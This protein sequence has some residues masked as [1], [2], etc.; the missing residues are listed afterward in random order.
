MKTQLALLNLLAIKAAASDD[1][2]PF[3]ARSSDQPP[4][5]TPWEVSKVCLKNSKTL[6]TLKW[7]LQD[8]SSGGKLEDDSSISPKESHCLELGDIPGISE[9]DA[10]STVAWKSVS[11]TRTECQSQHQV[12]YSSKGVT[13]AFTCDGTPMLCS[14]DDVD[15]TCE[16]AGTASGDWDLRTLVNGS[17]F[18][19]RW[20][21][22]FENVV[23]CD[24]VLFPKNDEELRAYLAYA[25][26]N[27]YKVRVAGGTHSATG[28]VSQSSSQGTNTV[29][30]SLGRYHLSDDSWCSEGDFCLDTSKGLARANA[31]RSWLDLYQAIRP[32]GWFVPTQTAGY[33][34]SIAGTVLGTVHGGAYGKTFLHGYVQ[35]MRVMLWD[36]TIQVIEGDEIR[37]WRSSYGLLGVLL[38]VE[39]EVIH[40]ETFEMYTLTSDYQ[41]WNE[42][43]F[44]QFVVGDAEAD[45]DIS[46]F[47]GSKDINQTKE[48]VY[49]EYFLDFLTDSSGDAHFRT[50]GVLWKTPPNPK[51]NKT[52]AE[53]REE[54]D[55]SEEEKG[56]IRER[57]GEKIDII[58]EILGGAPLM[59]TVAVANLLMKSN[60]MGQTNYVNTASDTVNDGFWVGGAPNVNIAA[61]FVPVENSFEA[62]DYVRSQVR[63]RHYGGDDNCFKFNNPVEYRFVE[64][65]DDSLLQIVPPGSYVVSEILGFVD[66]APAG[67]SWQRAY[68]EIECEWT[69]RHGGKPHL[70]KLHSFGDDD[71]DGNIDAMQPCKACTYFTDAQKQEFETIR[72]RY[73]PHGMFASG[74]AYNILL[75]ECPSNCPAPSACSPAGQPDCSSH[76]R[77][78]FV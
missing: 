78:L 49:G 63:E 11:L 62:F 58:N 37:N 14:L 23:T 16:E 20:K 21:N 42:Q 43:N 74:A 25:H 59:N 35:R 72:K 36:G 57:G 19:G 68:A 56:F 40:R 44:W 71:G 48:G 55:K 10:V 33:F 27:N 67:D 17:E 18:G 47:S 41:E 15:N 76:D 70:M 4:D 30:I 34:F 53:L 28:L 7:R 51:V 13:A 54:Y 12:H 22:W 2:S 32:L 65:T 64:V 39:V 60:Y 69:T 9:G 31:G 5:D 38:A 66:A 73:D 8:L 50:Q 77:S 6:T 24:T 46:F 3:C 26:E 45:L 52:E 29:S 75:A 1:G 61:Y